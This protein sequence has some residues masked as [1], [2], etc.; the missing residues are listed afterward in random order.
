MTDNATH[1]NTAGRS[2]VVWDDECDVCNRM[3]RV[4]ESRVRASRYTFCP[5]RVWREAHP[6]ASTEGM[7]LITPDG[8]A[9]FGVDAALHVAGLVWWLRPL[10]WSSRL[11][12]MHRVFGAAYRWF[13]SHRYQFGCS[14]DGSQSSCNVNTPQQRRQH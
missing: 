13:A 11:P 12:L 3:K 10:K 2:I 1:D 8:R 7:H 5:L 9:L 6:D 14:N 4:V